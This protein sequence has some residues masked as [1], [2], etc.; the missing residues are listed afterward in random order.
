[1]TGDCLSSFPKCRSGLG[2]SS[3][4]FALDQ[5]PGALLPAFACRSYLPLEVGDIIAVGILFLVAALVLSRLFFS[6]SAYAIV[7]IKPTYKRA[8]EA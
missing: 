7:H 3:M 8:R 1:M 5:A 2:P 4:A 6:L